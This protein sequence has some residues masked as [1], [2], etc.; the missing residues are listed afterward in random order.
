MNNMVFSIEKNDSGYVLNLY[1]L[2]FITLGKL[3]SAEMVSF[4]R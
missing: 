3:F 4:W 2:V 1:S